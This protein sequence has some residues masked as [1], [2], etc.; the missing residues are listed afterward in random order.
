M[1]EC[2]QETA[3]G[4]GKAIHWQRVKSVLTTTEKSSKKVNGKRVI[5]PQIAA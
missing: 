4:N 1:A 5:A 3:R 2:C